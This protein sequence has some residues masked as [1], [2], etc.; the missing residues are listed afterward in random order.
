[1]H[2]NAEAALIFSLNFIGETE[3]CDK[4]V[5]S[6]V[7]AGSF[8]NMRKAELGMS[9]KTSALKPRDANDQ[10]SF[11]KRKGVIGS[12]KEEL[13]CVDNA[14]IDDVIEPFNLK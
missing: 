6:S 5:Q 12:Y 7:Q 4:S 11:K 10:N 13:S 9:S 14:Y 2:C 8:D 1:M 3:I